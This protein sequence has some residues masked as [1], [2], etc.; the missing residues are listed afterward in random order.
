MKPEEIQ[1]L[2]AEGDN[3]QDT[4]EDICDE[5]L[6]SC[7]SVVGPKRQKKHMKIGM[8]NTMNDI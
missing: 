6:L 1:S 4:I 8:I 5:S 3:F 2:I 7:L